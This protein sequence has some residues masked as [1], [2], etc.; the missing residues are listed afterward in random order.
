MITRYLTSIVLLLCLVMPAKGVEK[1][2]DEQHSIELISGYKSTG[3]LNEIM[4]GLHFVMGEHWKTY[5]RES[6][7][8]GYP[9]KID[10]SN[11][12]NVKNVVINWPAPEQFTVLGLKA[13]GYENDF[14]LPIT[15]ILKD[16]G[17]EAVVDLKLD[18]LL[19][20]PGHCIQKKNELIAKL[21]PKDKSGKIKA[22]KSPNYDLI[23]RYLKLVPQ[24]DIGQGMTIERVEVDKSPQKY[25]VLKV[26]ARSSNGFKSPVLFLEPNAVLYADLP[27]VTF[28]S[29]KKTALFT[30][31]M[32]SNENKEL[33]PRADI[34]HKDIK[35]TLKDG[36]NAIEAQ[37]LPV[38]E[39]SA[40]YIWPTIIFFALIGGFILNF[41]PCVLPVVFLKVY[42]IFQ[43]HGETK[44]RIRK[45]LLMTVLGILSFFW[46]LAAL[47]ILV[48]SLGHSIAWGI[49]FQNPYFLV[50]I[51]IVLAL[52]AYNML[53]WFEI[54][55][56]SDAATKMN[57]IESGNTA[58]AHFFSG[59]FLTLLATPCTAPFVGV[60]LSF[61]LSRSAL[62]IFIIFTVMGLGLA[63]PFICIAIFPS[64]VNK[65][66][67]PG[68]WM[69][70]FKKSLSI[71]LFATL[72]WLLWDI[73][74]TN[75]VAAAYILTGL[76]ALMGFVLYLQ[77]RGAVKPRLSLVVV[78]AASI[79]AFSIPYFFKATEYEEDL[80]NTIWQK[81]DEAKIKEYVKQGKTVFV[82]VTAD[83]CLTCKVNEILVL[84][85]KRILDLF[86]SGKRIA[87]VADWTNGNSEITA[88]LL[89][90]GK[91]AV[92]FYVVFEPMD[93]D[94]KVLSEILSVKEVEDALKKCPVK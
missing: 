78:I 70:L 75:G 82:D 34:V 67:K 16:P 73:S 74:T 79:S 2:K 4:M 52:F 1:Y 21:D 19:C 43:S 87:M 31:R 61:A 71:L 46:M 57:R 76:F 86:S 20:D 28:S 89:R 45:N 13:Y 91:S 24:E 94:G 15:I 60:A 41:M 81:F 77:Y 30:I 6:G 63:L 90:F 35:L 50:G 47:V 14:V 54:I 22:V 7:L 65:L 37:R 26:Y 23:D 62:D 8:L 32:Y 55:I 5:W 69:V 44:L 72:I 11:S 48:R 42:S 66:P 9:I 36:D 58:L 84:R 27:E 25:Q 3:N 83:W 39:Q 17:K 12:V 10:F 80:S 68:Q 92:P 53:G 59:A 64:I 85:D 51:M 38:Q 40:F 33:P 93:P 29:N 56:S 88:F 18:Y 49:Q